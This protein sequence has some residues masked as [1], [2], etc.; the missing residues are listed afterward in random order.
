MVR[1]IK[2]IIDDGVHK[3]L[4]EDKDKIKPRTWVQYFVDDK[5]SQ[6]FNWGKRNYKNNRG[7]K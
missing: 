7:K 1:E 3:R 6:I 2:L 5:L 4:L